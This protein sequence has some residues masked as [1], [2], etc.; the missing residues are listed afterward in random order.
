M[1]AFGFP[2]VG[3]ADVL[4]LS[5]AIRHES[6]ILDGASKDKLVDEQNDGL[7][8]LFRRRPF[9]L[10]ELAVPDFEIFEE[11]LLELGFFRGVLDPAKGVQHA[12]G[13]TAARE[14]FGE[15]NCGERF[16]FE[17]KIAGAEEP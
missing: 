12:V 17:V 1:G 11:L 6:E 16:V 3:L 15:W 14:K 5:E 7:G 4:V 10:V 13:L 2:A 9:N 8:G